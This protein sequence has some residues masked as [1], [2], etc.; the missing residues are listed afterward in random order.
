[1]QREH[2]NEQFLVFQNSEPNAIN[3]W[4]NDQAKE[5]K[6]Y[7]MKWQLKREAEKTRN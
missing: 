5:K 2:H 3:G 6:K 1:M 4:M 7:H